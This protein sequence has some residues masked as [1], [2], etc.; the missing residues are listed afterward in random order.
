M[1]SPVHDGSPGENRLVGRGKLL[2][3]ALPG[4]DPRMYQVGPYLLLRDR[5]RHRTH[6]VPG[7][8]LAGSEANTARVHG[9]SGERH[10]GEI[11]ANAFANSFGLERSDRPAQSRGLT[12]GVDADVECPDVIGREAGMRG[13]SQLARDTQPARARIAID[14]LACAQ[15][16]GKVGDIESDAVDATDNQD[17]RRSLSL[18]MF[19]EH[20]PANGEIVAG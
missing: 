14:D 4:P 19:D 8:A 17:A 13:H 15:R 1:L 12:G 18:Q 3:S 9:E 5:P 16:A 6:G 20:L 7:V 10:V 11:D 2:C